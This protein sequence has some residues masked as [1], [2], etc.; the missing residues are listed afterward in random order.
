MDS[1]KLIDRDFQVHERTIG[2]CLLARDIFKKADS[3]NHY[4]TWFKRRARDLKLKRDEDYIIELAESKERRRPRKEHFV[5]INK[6]IC[7]CLR[8]KS[9]LGE[10]LRSKIA[11][12]LIE[13]QIQ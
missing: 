1:L 10:D 6:A 13:G 4:S 5:N 12:I 8:D 7:L 3:V 9:V 11:D 2:K